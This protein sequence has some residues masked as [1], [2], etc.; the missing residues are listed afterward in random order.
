MTVAQLANH[1]RISPAQCSKLLRELEDA[2]VPSRTPEGVLFS[3]RMVRDEATRN[4]R[5]AGGKAGAEHGSKGAEHGS[6]GGRPKGVE[7]GSETPLSGRE[8]PPPSSS[9]SSSPSGREKT[10]SSSATPTIPCPY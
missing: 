7:G 9:S 1:C 4:A 5:A 6:K 3:R 8:K 10:S 2:G